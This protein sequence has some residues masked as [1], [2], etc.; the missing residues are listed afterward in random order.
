MHSSPWWNKNHLLRY[1]PRLSVLSVTALL[2]CI[3]E[4][5]QSIAHPRK[6]PYHIQRFSLLLGSILEAE[7]GSIAIVGDEGLDLE[8]RVW[9]TT[10][11]RS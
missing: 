10:L 11:T 2:L 1:R 7:F 9:K 5:T 4:N 6:P 8:G 3:A